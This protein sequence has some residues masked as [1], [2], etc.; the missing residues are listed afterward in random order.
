MG[1][2]TRREAFSVE[3]NK[4]APYVLG[5]DLGGTNVR[6]AVLD[7]AGKLLGSGRAPSMATEGVENTVS[8]IVHAAK[9]AISSAGVK[10]E[11]IVGLGIGAWL[12]FGRNWQGLGIWI[13]LASGLA[14]VAMLMLGRWML[15]DRL[16]LAEYH[17]A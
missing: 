6:A 12:G 17:P 14:C 15:R 4:D 8:Q 7:R 1:R 11:E 10:P 9:T 13:G 2:L 3:F 5:A 16:R